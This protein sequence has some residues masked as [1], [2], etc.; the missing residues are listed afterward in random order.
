[1]RLRVLFILALSLMA[2]GVVKAQERGGCDLCGPTGTSQNQPK[3]NYSVT[4]RTS[5]IANGANSM[6]VG[7]ANKTVGAA[8][9]ALG[10]FAW[11]NATNAVVIGSGTGNT[12]DKALVN[13][14]SCSLM[15][16]F[17]SRKPTLFVGSSN[18][19]V[20]T[21]KVGIGNVTAP[22]AKLHV[23][24][25]ANED[26]GVILETSNKT[27]NKAYLQMLDDN[28]RIE[29]SREGMCIA[30]LN[31]ALAI[32]AKK[33]N[34]YGKMSLG[35]LTE[36]SAKFHIVSDN[37][38]DAG[39][40]LE[41][42]NKTKYS[43]FIQLFDDN[44]KIEVSKNGMR[45]MSM[46]DDMSFDAKKISM[47]GK[48]G[49][50]V[51]ND[52]TGGYDYSLAVNG[53]ILTTEVYVKEVDEWHDDVFSDDYKLMR[54]CDLEDFIQKNRHLPDIPSEVEVTE[55][56]YNMATMEG[57]LLKKIEELTLYTIELQKQLHRQQ[58]IVDG[59]REK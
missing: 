28:H 40:I 24:S 45:V 11:A 10:K 1:M 21:G 50:N 52:F 44:H 13:S 56:G 58:E 49:I 27:A 54:L 16:G 42:S 57:L 36:P 7:Q 9:L 33:I 31:D 37:N 48:I 39:M 15:V 55:K 51:D 22:Q 35:K 12:S 43:A 47:N 14:Y 53:G 5:N 3:G 18:G 32:D 30:S 6:A 41:T 25:D 34:M 38:E 8:S 4:V 26:A 46:N 20:T 23:L 29:V 17:N 59:L 19:G 2:N